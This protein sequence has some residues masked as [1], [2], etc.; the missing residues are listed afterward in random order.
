[1]TIPTNITKKQ[2]KTMAHHLKP[3]VMIG[4]A[5]LTPAVHKEIDQSLDAHELIKIKLPAADA[6]EKKS[7]R[8]TLC[9]THQAEMIQ[10]V[11]RTITLFRRKPTMGDH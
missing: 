10:H 8:T 9:A 4:Q 2:L 1:M 7:L 3:V 11:G 5:G 6:S